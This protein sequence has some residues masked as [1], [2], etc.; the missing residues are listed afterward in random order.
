MRFYDDGHYF[1]VAQ[2]LNGEILYVEVR[3][4][5]G[6]MQYE[7][8]KGWHAQRR[9]TFEELTGYWPQVSKAQQWGEIGLQAVHRDGEGRILVRYQAF[10]ASFSVP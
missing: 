1:V 2:N 7:Y 4:H 3:W 9:S 8:E 10:S 5:L 6:S